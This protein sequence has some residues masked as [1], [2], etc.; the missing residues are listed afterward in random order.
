M[1]RPVR[2]LVVTALASM[3]LAAGCVPDAG[4]PSTCHD[5]SVRFEA[6][7][8]E[9]RL[10]PANFAACRDQEV[11]IA[12]TIERDGILHLHGYDEDVPA[13]SV[14]AGDEVDFTFVAKAGAFPI[15]LH[16]DDG[17]AEVTVGTLTVHEP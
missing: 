6:T 4:L 16:T 14:H 1:R 17:P 9:E 8:V 15:A 11:T 2:G 12:F 5:P 13:T 10:E 3:A 7:L